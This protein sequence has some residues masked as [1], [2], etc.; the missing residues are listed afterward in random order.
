MYLAQRTRHSIRVAA[1]AAAIYIAVVAALAWAL[2]GSSSFGAGFVK[3][4]VGIPLGLAVYGLL[5]WGGDKLVSLPLWNRMPSAARVLLLAMV[6]A[7]FAFAVV[8]IGS[9]WHA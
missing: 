7:L 9:Q 3:W 8:V 6:V 4:F 1:L 2:P 5:E